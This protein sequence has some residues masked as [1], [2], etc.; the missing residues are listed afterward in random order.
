MGSTGSRLRLRST[1]RHNDKDACHVASIAYQ[2]QTLIYLSS[3]PSPPTP[4]LPRRDKIHHVLWW[5]SVLQNKRKHRLFFFITTHWGH[6]CSSEVFCFSL[7]V[8]VFAHF[9][10]AIAVFPSLTVFRLHTSVLH[11]ILS[12]DFPTFTTSP[13]QSCPHQSENVLWNTSNVDVVILWCLS[14][15]QK[16]KKEKENRSFFIMAVYELTKSGRIL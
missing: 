4:P 8:G 15:V 14:F 9:V 3:P 6:L 11:H 16:K 1:S 12:G 5:A 10:W 7:E 13:V 2:N